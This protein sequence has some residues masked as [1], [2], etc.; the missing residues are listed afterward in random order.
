MTVNK[1]DYLSLSPTYIISV[2]YVNVL[3]S[4]LNDTLVHTDLWGWGYSRLHRGHDLHVPRPDYGTG[5][6]PSQSHPLLPTILK[7]TNTATE[8]RAGR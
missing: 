6:H 8:R 5:N 3:N 1:E 4:Q 2:E 7:I